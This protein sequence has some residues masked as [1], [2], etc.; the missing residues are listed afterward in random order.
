MINLNPL[1]HFRQLSQKY[2]WEQP[3]EAESQSLTNSLTNFLQRRSNALAKGERA[4]SEIQ[5]DLNRE[6]EHTPDLERLCTKLDFAFREAELAERAM[7]TYWNLTNKSPQKSQYKIKPTIN[8]TENITTYHVSSWFLA[9]CLSFLTSDANGYEK[10]QFVTGI[11]LSEQARTL[12]RMVNVVHSH[13]SEIGAGA[14]QTD[15]NK[16]LIELSEHWAHSLHAIFHSHPGRGVGATR[17][18][19]TD[20]DT[21][22]RYEKA[23]PAIGAIFVKDG[24]VRFFSEDKPFAIAIHGRGVIPIDKYRHVYKINL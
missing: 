5:K 9:D 1:Q 12:E 8:I 4:L 7:E 21:H 20:F 18:S 13:Q 15:L 14:D 24:F 2:F 23:Y 22:R 11:K 17:P 19:S 6:G 10:L 3:S 16:T